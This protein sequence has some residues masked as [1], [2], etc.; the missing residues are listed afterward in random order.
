MVE[1]VMGTLIFVLVVLMAAARVK[2]RLQDVDKARDRVRKELLDGGETAKIRIFE[3]HPLS[4]VQIIEVARSEGFAY[5]GVG[6]EGA[7]YAAL[8]FVKGTGRHD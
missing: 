8:D 7:G 3:S 2:A 5:R 4:D 6:A 1:L